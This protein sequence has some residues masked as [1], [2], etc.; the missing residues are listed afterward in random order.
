MVG[1]GKVCH[2]SSRDV[3][4]QKPR[5]LDGSLHRTTRLLVGEHVIPT[6]R[7]EFVGSFH[8]LILVIWMSHQTFG[9]FM[10]EVGVTWAYDAMPSRTSPRWTCDG[11]W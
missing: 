5:N 3:C 7:L 8:E 4:V 10:S 2:N 1:L 9:Y 6:L 11:G